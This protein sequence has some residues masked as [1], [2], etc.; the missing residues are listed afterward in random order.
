MREQNQGHHGAP[1]VTTGQQCIGSNQDETHN[2]ENQIESIVWL[3]STYSMSLLQSLRIWG[4]VR[5]ISVDSILSYEDTNESWYV[6]LH[7]NFLY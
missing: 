2:S 5:N 7:N 1:W 6:L 3:L 4:M